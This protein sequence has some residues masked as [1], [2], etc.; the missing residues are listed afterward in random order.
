MKKNKTSQSN[1]NTKKHSPNLNSNNPSRGTYDLDEYRNKKR[2]Y[3]NPYADMGTGNV[4]RSRE[5]TNS[6][7]YRN[8]YNKSNKSNTPRY[9][10]PYED[11]YT[12]SSY[13]SQSSYTPPPPIYDQQEVH[14]TPEQ[15]KAEIRS[16]N[17]MTRKQLQAQAKRRKRRMMQ[18]MTVGVIIT[19]FITY[20]GL[21]VIDLFR[22]PSISYQT[23]QMG[24]MD[25]S[26]QL[27]GII[28]RDEQ[29]FNSTRS[30][31][32]HYILSEGE[33]VSKQGS[34][35]LVAQSAEIQSLK[36]Q[37]YTLDDSLYN[38]QEKRS[39]LSYYQADLYQINEVLK[40]EMDNFIDSKYWENP[41]SVYELRQS[42]DKTIEDRTSLYVQDESKTTEGFQ[43]NREAIINSLKNNQ[44]SQKAAT[45][46]IVSYALDGYETKLNDET[47][48]TLQYDQYKELLAE[49]KKSEMRLPSVVAEA[50]EPL[51]KI[52]TSDRWEIVTYIETEQ[53]NTY[54]VGT[55]YN[56]YFE[57][58][59]QD[60]IRFKLESKQEE[61]ETGLTKLVF[62]SSD[63]LS[64]FLAYR[65]V[66][67]S[68]GQNKA[69][70]LKIP[71]KAIVEKNMLGIPNEY[72]VEQGREKG[73][74]KKQ[75]QINVFMPL[76]IQYSDDDFSYIMQQIDQLDGI[77]LNSVIEHPTEEKPYTI[78]D[79]Q[80]VQGVYVVNGQFAQFK[81]IEV[82]MTNKE[83]AILTQDKGTKLKE[84]D[85]IISN[86]K[87][88]KEDQLLK[89]MNVQNE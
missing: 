53:A 51:Y 10:S 65:L 37:L 1:K 29:V 48:E 81:R 18:K 63:Y 20:A 24:V 27:K 76:N 39:D 34:V 6:N 66:E 85:Q 35:C 9:G 38:K 77:G 23:V 19:M 13:I 16:K 17:K 68:I 78:S 30:G 28:F 64:D 59:K 11:N 36:D 4:D 72:I 3:Y 21:K 86:P 47:M 56:L 7:P 41:K 8:Q 55:Y 42:L 75:N 58:T 69:E 74:F 84:F 70:G 14:P 15:R 5:K 67:F 61:V 22:Y 87:N 54:D 45:S 60:K 12:R 50:N 83:Y 79:M 25:N 44:S 52:I 33:K 62:S 32:I 43:S 49:T 82:A 71:L 2:N 80:T 26:N 89:Y 46:G 88:I 57:D 31:D 73:V 40:K